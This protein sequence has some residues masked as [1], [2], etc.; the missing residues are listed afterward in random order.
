[1]QPF[2]GREPGSNGLAI[3]SQGRLILCEHGDRRVRR[4]EKDGSK[5][6]LADRY[7]GKRLNSPNDCALRSDGTLCFTDPPFGLR[8][9]F[10]DPAREL[11]FCGVYCVAPDGS[12]A[13]LTRELRAPNGLAFSPKEDVLYVSNADRNHPVWMAY[14]VSANGGLDAGRVFASAARWIGKRAGGPDG[15][16]VDQGG[17]VFAAGPGGV[18]VLSPDGTHLGTIVTNVAT[19]NC[20][21]GEDG[22]A[23]FIAASTSIYRIR[24]STQ[25]VDW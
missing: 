18:Y 8:Q 24:T 23:L 25:G 2:E 19:S 22:S 3:D 21:F 16:K 7:L 15:I 5:T 9:A 6:T 4:L 20:A 12:L 14:A 13:L 17:H 11:E 1:M 10:D